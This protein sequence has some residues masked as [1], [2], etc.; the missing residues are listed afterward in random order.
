VTPLL[1]LLFIGALFSEIRA[2]DNPPERLRPAAPHPM[3]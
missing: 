3:L 2:Q 1:V